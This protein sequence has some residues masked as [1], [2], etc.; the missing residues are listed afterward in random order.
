MRPAF[1]IIVD[2]KTDITSKIADRLVTL[3]VHDEA[4]TKSD[5]LTLAIDD[6]DQVL[7]IPR[8]G[9]KLDVSTGYVGQALVKRG[10]FTVD[11]VSVSGP[12][13][14]MTIRANSADMTG[15]V[16]APKERS[17]HDK[18]FGEVVQT[19][20]KDNGL[21]P[22]IPA[23]LASIDLGHIDQTE[24]DMQLLSRLCADNGAVFKI[25]DDKLIVSDHASG[26]SSSGKN[27][28]PVTIDASQCEEWDAVLSERG[29]Y[30]TAKAYWQD[31]ETGERTEVV[32][33]EDEPSITLK[34]SYKTE[35]DAYRAARSKLKALGR[36]T[37]TVSI[38]GMVGDPSAFAESTATLTSFR[39][40]VDGSGWV[41]NTVIHSITGDK[42]T[43][44]IELERKDP[45]S[46]KQAAGE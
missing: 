40:G 3:E 31:M 9:A 6:R 2:G 35:A 24:S 5:R 29:Q 14:L 8:K 13:R 7:E 38:N 30:G 16:K 42:Y 17:F 28:K 41:I 19:V 45:G 37:G 10:I 18:T 22:A 39:K 20:A 11:E 12:L 46:G 36:N 26:K 27:L 1:K 23:E 32:V 43:C 33:G 4:G 44:N 25:A 21:T 34:H 15:G